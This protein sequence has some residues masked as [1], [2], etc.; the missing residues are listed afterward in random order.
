MRERAE[1]RGKLMTLDAKTLR[2]I[3]LTVRTD[4]STT[5]RGEAAD[6]TRTISRA[7]GTEAGKFY[8][9]VRG[10]GSFEQMGATDESI[11]KLYVTFQSRQKPKG[12]NGSATDP[13]PLERWN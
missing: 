3:R 2:V 1:A 10:R 5:A 6:S 8:R 7:Y 9:F 4:A 13:T 11:A 12:G